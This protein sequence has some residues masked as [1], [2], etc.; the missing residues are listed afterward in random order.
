MIKMV[1]MHIIISMTTIFTRKNILKYF[2]LKIFLFKRKRKRK[3]QQ[4]FFIIRNK[5]I[6]IFFMGFFNKVYF[7]GFMRLL[8]LFFIKG[9]FN[10]LFFGTNMCSRKEGDICVNELYNLGLF[11]IMPTKEKPLK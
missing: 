8:I 1:K 6:F 11:F 10:D 9:L 2:F 4:I 7:M 5:E 3:G